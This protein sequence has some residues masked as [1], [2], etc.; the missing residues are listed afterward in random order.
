[1]PT[2]VAAAGLAER[3]QDIL[4]QFGI[5][6][7]YLLMQVISFAI[8]AYVLY[9]FLLKPVLATMGERQKQIDA[10]LRYAEEMKAKLSQ[11]QQESADII[12]QAQTEGARLVDETRRTAKE[13]LD[14]QQKDATVRANEMITKA[15]QAIELEHKKMLEETKTEVARLVVA[16]TQRVLAKELSDAD[17]ARYNEAATRELT[18]V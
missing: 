13:F 6:G 1:M 9:R 10:G 16:T 4:H 17:R 11:A 8:L 14:T 15:Q 18:Q 2:I 7:K 5:E 3:F 12:K